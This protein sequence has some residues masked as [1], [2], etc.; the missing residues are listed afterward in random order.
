VVTGDSIRKVAAVIARE[1]AQAA[2]RKDELPAPPVNE[3]TA[4]VLAERKR[5]TFAEMLAFLQDRQAD[6][7]AVGEGNFNFHRAPAAVI[8]GVYPCRDQNFLK[9]GVAAMENFMLAAAARGLGTCWSNAVSICQE[10]VR[11]ALDLPSDLI[12]VDGIAVGYPVEGSPIND[13]PRRRLPIEDVTEW[14][15]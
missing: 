15:E 11:A 9:S 13:I 6:M 2:A 1:Y 5:E 10:S 14:R 12:L 8:F 4:R 7:K 3:E